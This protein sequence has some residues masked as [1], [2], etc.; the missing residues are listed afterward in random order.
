[1]CQLESLRFTCA[2]FEA[3]EAWVIGRQARLALR[4][5]IGCVPTSS[6][7]CTVKTSICWSSESWIHTPALSSF[8]FSPILPWLSHVLSSSGQKLISMK[9]RLPCLLVGTVCW[10][11]TFVCVCVY[12]YAIFFPLKNMQCASDCLLSISTTC[13]EDT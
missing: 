5:C 8:L 1:M 11:T 2:A 13:Y 9:R 12:I 7:S 10:K 3:I 4:G 6:G